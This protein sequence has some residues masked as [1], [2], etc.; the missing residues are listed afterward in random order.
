LEASFWKVYEKESCTGLRLPVRVS[1]DGDEE[2]FVPAI[3]PAKKRIEASRDWPLNNPSHPV[4]CE[5]HDGGVTMYR[6]EATSVAGF[7]QQLAVAYVGRGY[8]FYVTG[9]IPDRKDP[10]AVDE[11]LI[12]KYGLAIGKASRARRKAAGL[13]NVQYLRY[14]RAFVLL[15]TPGKHLFFEEEREFI[16]DARKVPIKFAGYSIS[17]RAGHPHVRIE[18]WRYRELKAYVADIACHRSKAHL[19]EEF[20]GVRFEPYAPVRSQLH[21]ILREVNRRRSLSQYEAVSASCIRVRRH[22]V[23]PFEP[24]LDLEVQAA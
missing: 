17:Y 2:Y 14:G 23:A 5:C 4:P 13:A 19:E 16:R 12:A 11:K 10:H 1:S 6:C 9:E 20:R 18:E 7:V 22:V 3:A 8:W 24:A 21:C 15:A